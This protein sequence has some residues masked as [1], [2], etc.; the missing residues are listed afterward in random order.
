MAADQILS[1]LIEK[2]EKM[3]K[4]CLSFYPKLWK[5]LRDNWCRS[6]LHSCNLVN[7]NQ[8]KG[9]TDKYQ[10]VEFGDIYH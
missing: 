2:F 4:E 8:G 10:T 5:I 7:W 1:S 3:S 6:L 9:Q